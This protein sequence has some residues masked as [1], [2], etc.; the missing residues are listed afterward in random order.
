MW[1]GRKSLKKKAKR[2]KSWTKSLAKKFGLAKAKK[3]VEGPSR[4]LTTPARKQDSHV[5][6]LWRAQN[7]FDEKR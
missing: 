2:R 7:F 6:L 1:N 4:A 5:L 3:R